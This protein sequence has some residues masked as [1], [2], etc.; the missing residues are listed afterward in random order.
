MTLIEQSEPPGECAGCHTP[1]EFIAAAANGDVR[2][3]LVWMDGAYAFLCEP[4]T[5][6]Y[7]RKRADQYRNTPYGA[8]KGI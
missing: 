1:T 2:M 5:S 4:C 8:A 6:E 3:G 7:E